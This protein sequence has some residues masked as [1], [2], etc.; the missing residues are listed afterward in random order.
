MWVL[1][2]VA[3]VEQI[4]SVIHGSHRA[5]LSTT[6]SADGRTTAR[7]FLQPASVAQASAPWAPARNPGTF[8]PSSIF[9]AGREQAREAGHDMRTGWQWVRARDVASRAAARRG[10]VSWG[11]G[12]TSGG[13]G[14]LPRPPSLPA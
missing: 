12:W 13:T 5:A 9:G 3:G 8:A 6:T 4:G 2:S 7:G 1:E 11:E 10:F 14:S